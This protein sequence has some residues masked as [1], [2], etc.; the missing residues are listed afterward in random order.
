[1]T[2]E[3]KSLISQFLMH[4]NVSEKTTQE[5]IIQNKCKNH[6]R[7]IGNNKVSRIRKPQKDKVL[8]LLSDKL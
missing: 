5:K 6:L 4:Q 3:L 8:P 2:G 1:M 7:F